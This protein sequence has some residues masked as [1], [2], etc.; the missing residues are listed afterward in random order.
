MFLIFEVILLCFLLS[1]FHG[2][3]PVGLWDNLLEARI[4]LQKVVTLTNQ[5]PQSDA[6]GD[7]VGS[8]GVELQEALMKGM[9]GFQCDN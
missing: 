5:M 7:F 2:A 3:P 9:W 4:K 6:L 8:G 1:I